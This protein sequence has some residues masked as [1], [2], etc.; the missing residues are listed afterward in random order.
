MVFWGERSEIQSQYSEVKMNKRRHQRV[1]PINLVAN[2]S[3]GTSFFSGTV[4][5]IS[6]QGVQVNY[7]RENFE[8]PTKALSIVISVSGILNFKKMQGVLRWTSGTAP[9]K[10][11]GIH[12]TDA[13]TSWSVFVKNLEPKET[14]IK[15]NCYE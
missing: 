10:K 13:S 2:V 8:E 9:R 1:E 5:D 3:A 7:I 6:R 4:C 14:D 12:I 15:V 11:M